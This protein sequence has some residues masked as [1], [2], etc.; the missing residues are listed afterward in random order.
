MA[1][2]SNPEILRHYSGIDEASRL[3]TGWFQLEA[4]RT[5]ELIRRRLVPPPATILDVGGGAGAYACWLASSGYSVHLIDPIPKHVEQ[6]CAASAAQPERPLASIA[7]GD[8]R[9][10]HQADRSIDAVL[11]LGPLYHLTEPGERLQAL[12]EAHRVPRPGGV[13]WAAAINRFASLLDSLSS[14]F[15]SDPVFAPI[16]E[17]DLADG[18]HRNPTPNP[19]YFTDAFFHRPEE[20]LPPKSPKPDSA[21]RRFFLSKVRAGWLGISIACGTIPSSASAC[22]RPYAGWNMSPH[23]WALPLT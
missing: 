3:Q 1:G 5:R 13:V 16:V 8:A 17:R 15:F 2:D 14:G 6:A 9:K 23:F 22:S 11:L 21:W 18:Q 19:I 12:R 10:L 20:G 7:L 4:E